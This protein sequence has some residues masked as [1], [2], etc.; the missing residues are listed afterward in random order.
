MLIA[1][2]KLSLPEVTLC[3]SKAINRLQDS[4]P[5]VRKA[6]LMLLTAVAETY[7]LSVKVFK[8]F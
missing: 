4:M 8:F 6:T 3:L 7:P 2:N 1:N 5:T